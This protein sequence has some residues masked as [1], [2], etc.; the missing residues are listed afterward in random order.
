MKKMLFIALLFIC[1]GLIAQDKVFATQMVDSLTSENFAGRG[2][3]RDGHVKA[4]NF[5]ARKFNEFGLKRFDTDFKQKFK[6]SINTFGGACD[7]IIDK[8]LMFAGVDFLVDP[9]C[10]SITGKFDLVWLNPKIV[11]DAK[12]MIK[13]TSTDF[14]NSFL[15]VDKTGITDTTQLDFLDNMIHNPFQAKGIIIVQ[16]KKFTW[17]MCQQQRPYPIF[18]IKKDRITYKNKKIEVTIDA[19]LKKEE[20]TQN[21]LGYIKGTEYPDS[22]LV[23]SAH[24]DHLGMMGPDALFEGANDNAS[25][26]ALILDLARHYSLPENAPKH[27]I[28]FIAFGAEEVGLIGSNYYV[29]KPYF[30]LKQIKLQINTDIMGTGDEGIMMVNGKTHPKIYEAFKKINSDKGYLTKI[31]ARGR[32]YNSDHAPFDYK[33]VQSV[34]IYTKGGSTAYHDIY[35]TAENL[36]LSKY[37][38]VFQL[39][40]DFIT[41]Y[42]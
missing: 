13:F 29:E 14:S 27:S 20:I 39:I 9:S 34:F 2:Y 24:Y 26:T 19:Q 21:V 32:S 16:N 12:K 15:I 40:K 1:S 37:N 31:G 35:D 8:K 17:S 28:L 7:L 38:E 4:A 22:F 5:I 36:T 3:V 10:P 25:G 30:P 6:I 23:L 33:G 18:Y 11:G 42:K 41:E